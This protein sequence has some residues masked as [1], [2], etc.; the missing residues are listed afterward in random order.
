[1]PEDKKK[2]KIKGDEVALIAKID[3]DQA[4]RPLEEIEGEMPVLPLRNMII[5]PEIVMPV[6][7]GR[8]STLELVKS[9][10]KRKVPV[11][12]ATQKDAMVEE[13]DLNDLY[14]LGVVGRIVRILELPGGTTNALIHTCGPKVKL[15][16]IISSDPYLVGT[17]TP[18]E[19]NNVTPRSNEFKAIMSTCFDVMKKLHDSMEE[20]GND[21]L[22]ALRDMEGD[23]VRINFICSNFPLEITSKYELLKHDSIKDRA[24]HLIG[25][26]NEQLEI[27]R[28]KQNIQMRT[29]EERDKQQSAYFLQQQ[30]K[31]IQ[32]ELGNGAESEI[33]NLRAQ[34]KKKQWSKEVAEIFEKELTKL[35][36][37]NPQS[38]DY[39][40]QYSY[41]QNLLALPWNVYTPQSFNIKSAEKTLNHDHYGL[42][43]VKERILEHLAVLKLKGDM[44]SPILCLYGP[45]GV[46]KLRLDVP[47]LRL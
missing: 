1:M 25:Y 35:E 13:P 8:R 40:V 21:F 32:D 20:L 27:A 41:L 46:G 44:K 18:V 9:A 17:A 34:G 6:A 7:I 31:N 28:L 30:L 36:R 19:E 11:I 43:K 45:P 29:S 16:S 24:I 39:N 37:I 26:L 5:F 38:P 12:L 42:E 33:D 22:M 15:D 4:S 10:Y 23:A 47:L 3:I 2:K 14:P